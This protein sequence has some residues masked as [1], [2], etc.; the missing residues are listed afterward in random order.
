MISS[1]VIRLTV[2]CVSKCN[3]PEPCIEEPCDITI[4]PNPST[5]TTSTT[6]S[7]STTT[8]SSSSTTTT[9]TTFPVVPFLQGLKIETLYMAE[10][11]DL[12]LLPSSYI[13]PCPLEIGVHTCNRAFFQV[14]G[15]DV[16]IGDSLMN[17]GDGVGGTVTTSGKLVCE[18]Y[19]NYPAALTG[20]TWTGYTGDSGGSR[21]SVM[22]ITGQQAIDIANV[23]VG[24][25]NIEFKLIATMTTYNTTCYGQTVPHENVTWIRISKP[26]GTVIYNGCPI[27][28]ILTLNI[29]I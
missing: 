7:S 12:D 10:Q 17:N 14:T 9:S 6:S 29:C 26:D 3:T 16:Y 15:N 11:S 24:N 2:G 5:T 22:T 18:D 19:Y 13:H 21:Y 25:C 23:N 28:N 4:V 20:G 8:T 1:K 27:N